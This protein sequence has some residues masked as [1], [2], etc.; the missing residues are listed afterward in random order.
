MDWCSK[1]RSA[2]PGLVCKHAYAACSRDSS[3]KMIGIG[4]KRVLDEQAAV[5]SKSEKYAVQMR[6]AH[7]VRLL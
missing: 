2:D 3:P 1:I 5:L 6:L 4:L 7:R